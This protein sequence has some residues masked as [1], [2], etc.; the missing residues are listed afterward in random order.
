MFKF[1]AGYI[2]HCWQTTTHKYWVFH[3]TIKFCVK[4]KNFKGKV[5]LIFR[6]LFH[7]LSKYRWSEAKSFAK[8]IF[9][10]RG[11]TY[12]SDIYRESL[13]SIKPSV[14]LH[15]KRNSHHPEYWA[16]LE[17]GRDG[18]S[19]MGP[20]EKIEMIIDWRAA[21]RRHSDGCI[22]KSLDIN[23][24]RFGYGDEEKEYLTTIAK[25]IV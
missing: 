18:F 13:R 25:L 7:D 20:Y 8:V 5:S 23:Q 1:T 17:S 6:S 15:Y 10:L 14:I 19:K 16:E 21:T 2:Y 11:Q 4:K 24:E 3:Y 12:G 9:K 22:F